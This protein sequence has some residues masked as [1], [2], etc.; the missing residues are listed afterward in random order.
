MRGAV[1]G[2]GKMGVL[3]AALLSTIPDV[4]ITTICEKSK[5]VRMVGSKITDFKFVDDIEKIED[6]DFVYVTTP[7]QS[8]FGI[9]KQLYWMDI[10][11][12][13]CEKPLTMN[14]DNS[15]EIGSSY[16]FVH[17][18]VNMVGYNRRFNKTFQKVKQMVELGVLGDEIKCEGYAYSSNYI[19]KKIPLN[20]QKI[21]VMRD[22]GCHAI[23]LMKW[24]SGNEGKC[25][26]KASW[27]KEGYR[28]PEIGVRVS[29]S[30]GEVFANEDKVVFGEM[31]YFKQDLEDNVSYYLGGSDYIREDEE[32]IRAIRENR[33]VESDFKSASEVDYIV[34][35]L[36]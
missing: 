27:Q 3:H 20:L 26:I 15:Y 29:G 13:F 16:A 12:I 11:N 35:G 9:I 33:E 4:E 21:G 19:D 1:I 36:C 28:L 18:G 25:K 17:K 22:L 10:N 2:F 14:Y 6:V 7:P 5:L 30:K 8:H 31:T 34:E 23:D 24:Y 32:F